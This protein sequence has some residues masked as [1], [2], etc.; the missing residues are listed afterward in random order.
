MVT[1]NRVKSHDDGKIRD[2]ISFFQSVT[3]VGVIN[4]AKSE[5][6]AEE[7][8]KTKF[9]RSDFTEGLVSRSPFETAGTEEWHNG[10]EEPNAMEI[11]IDECL[12]TQIAAK[13]G[14][15]TDALTSTDYA[16]FIQQ[17]LQ[18]ELKI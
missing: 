8:A 12:K 9:H 10:S 14:T 11:I 2:Y 6:E 5:N 3:T 1:K 16:S 7:L 17:T 4:K 18:K 15:V 13:L